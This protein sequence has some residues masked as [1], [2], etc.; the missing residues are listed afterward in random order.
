MEPMMAEWWTRAIEEDVYFFRGDVYVRLESNL[1][2][3]VRRLNTE[4][5]SCPHS[6]TAERG[7]C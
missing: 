4:E 2:I 3:T 5:P 1:A 7:S 6:L